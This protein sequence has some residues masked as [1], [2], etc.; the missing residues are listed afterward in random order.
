[1]FRRSFNNYSGEH[2]NLINISS[3]FISDQR[4]WRICKWVFFRSVQLVRT[5]ANY[6]GLFHTNHWIW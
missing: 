2:T 4:H 6:T 3:S 1:M 5:L